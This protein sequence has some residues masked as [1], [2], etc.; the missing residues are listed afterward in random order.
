MSC[1]QGQRVI[2]GKCYSEQEHLSARRS[3]QASERTAGEPDQQVPDPVDWQ[4]T[5]GPKQYTDTPRC[6]PSS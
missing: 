1:S 2:A 3:Q 4:H 6:S 5:P